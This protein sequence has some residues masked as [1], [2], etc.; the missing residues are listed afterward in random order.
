MY[1]WSA[2]QIS[3]GATGSDLQNINMAVQTSILATGVLAV[4][5]LYQ[6]ACS[7]MFEILICIDN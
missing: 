3:L 7:K 5:F 2:R 1:C 4:L 6:E